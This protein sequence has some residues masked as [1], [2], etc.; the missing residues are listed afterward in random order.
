M[1]SAC[2]H[3]NSHAFIDDYTRIRHPLTCIAI[4]IYIHWH[5]LGAGSEFLVRSCRA[6]DEEKKLRMC[7]LFQTVLGRRVT[8]T[9]PDSARFVYVQE[10]VTTV[11]GT[12]GGLSRRGAGRHAVQQ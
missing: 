6:A 1:G 8:L 4:S 5:H 7:L 11:D 3:A 12:A 9:F 10:H 2:L